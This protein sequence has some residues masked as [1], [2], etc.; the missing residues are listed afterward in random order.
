M[1]TILNNENRGKVRVGNSEIMLNA[2]GNPNLKLI[3][4]GNKTKG[5]YVIAVP[6][7]AAK[8]KG[9]K[10]IYYDIVNKAVNYKEPM[11]AILNY[12]GFKERVPFGSR[13]MNVSNMN[14]NK[15][16]KLIA[17]NRTNYNRYMNAHRAMNSR[18]KKLNQMF[19]NRKNI[20]FERP[21][22]YTRVIKTPN[23]KAKLQIRLSNNV[24]HYNSGFTDPN[25]RGRGHGKLLRSVPI[26][27]A[28]RAGYKKIVQTS[29]W[30]N[31]N[32]Y[33][34]KNKNNAP[35]SSRIMKRLGFSVKN[36]RGSGK[37]KAINSELI[38]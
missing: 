21:K 36:V 15:L 2:F 3:N 5:P 18:I 8:N 27:I 26:N 14:E 9:Y 35:P 28:K 13:K 20:V 34:V 29:V 6:L 23:H 4:L 11:N 30:E 31:K 25:A 32:Q 19:Q 10:K 7:V 17:G 1:N 37:N 12:L 16:R 24:M 33:G 38:L 22:K